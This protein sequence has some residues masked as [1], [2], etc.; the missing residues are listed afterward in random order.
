MNQTCTEHVQWMP[1]HTFSRVAAYLA[2]QTA[3]EG[4]FLNF[5]IEKNVH[6]N[7]ELLL[8]SICIFITNC[9]S[10]VIGVLFSYTIMQ[11]NHVFMNS[12]E[13]YMVLFVCVHMATL[14]RYVYIYSLSPDPHSVR[15]IE[16]TRNVEGGWGW[17]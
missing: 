12:F 10:H 9:T 17:L 11:N 1:P 15:A 14:V 16:Y 5:V 6:Q 2:D 3:E 4:S 7:C 13:S 8:R